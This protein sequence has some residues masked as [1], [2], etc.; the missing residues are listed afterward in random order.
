MRCEEQN[1]FY[2]TGACIG[3]KFRKGKNIL[4]KYN[5]TRYIDSPGINIKHFESFVNIV[6]SKKDTFLGS[7]LKL[8]LVVRSK[9]WPTSTPKNLEGG[10]IRFSAI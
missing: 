2:K 5:I 7:K 1:F 6:V 8:A 9:V 4:I 10:M 3:M